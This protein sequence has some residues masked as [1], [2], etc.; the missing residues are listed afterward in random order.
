MDLMFSFAFFVKL[1]FIIV[2]VIYIIGKII[3]LKYYNLQGEE[4]GK[5]HSRIVLVFL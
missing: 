2:I 4:K 3:A 5:L 1:L